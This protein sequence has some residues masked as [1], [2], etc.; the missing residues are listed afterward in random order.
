LDS[1][2]NF[3]KWRLHSPLLLLIFLAANTLHEQ[4]VS[5][6]NGTARALYHVNVE[7]EIAI[8]RKGD[9]S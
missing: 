6:V 7:I 4:S 3:R 1:T 8:Q 2:R 9:A 5:L